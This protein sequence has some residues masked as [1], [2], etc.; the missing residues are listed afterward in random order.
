M[1]RNQIS[2]VQTLLTNVSYTRKTKYRNSTIPR[3]NSANLFT[4]IAFTIAS[5]TDSR[6]VISDRFHAL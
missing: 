2:I 5:G 1:P 4:T 3:S 6:Q